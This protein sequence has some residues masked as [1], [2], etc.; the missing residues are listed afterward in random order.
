MKTFVRCIDLIRGEVDDLET[1]GFL[2]PDLLECLRGAKWRSATAAVL[3]LSPTTAE[4]FR[5]AFTEHLAKV[6]FGEAYEP[7]AKGRL[8]E[9][10]IDRFH[11]Q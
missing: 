1:A 11:A 4:K 8:L 5:E 3:E 9:S 10:L 2:Q 7:T 6:G